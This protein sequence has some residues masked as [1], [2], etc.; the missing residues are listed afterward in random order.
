M[1]RRSD[2]GPGGAD[3]GRS[4]GPNAGTIAWESPPGTSAPVSGEAPSS[5]T[6]FDPLAPGYFDDPYPHYA[7]LRA[8]GP[9]HYEPQTNSYLVARYDD[10]T[11][12]LR[13]RSLMVEVSRGTPNA[14]IANELARN[15]SLEAGADKWMVFRDGDDHARL[16]RLVSQV[17]TPKAV[18]A[19]RRRTHAI[20]DHLLSQAAE[21]D[22]FDVITEF[23]RP[24][25]AQIISEMLGVP[26]P[27]IPQMLEWSHHL[28]YNVESF[29]PPEEERAIVDSTR[30]MT[31]Y[32]R[33]LL[34]RKRAH[35]DA[36]LLTALLAAGDA[37]DHLSADEIVAQ[38]VFLYFAGHETTMD[39]IGNGL[40]HLFEEPAQLRRLRDDPSIEEP[41]IEELLRFDPPLQFT[42]RFTTR[43]FEL[44]GT[45]IPAGAD[46]LL[47]LAAANR[48]PAKWG[49]DADRLDLIRPDA[50]NHLS[51][52]SGSHYCLGA[53][54]ARLEA[55]IAL[56]GLL[57]RFPDLAPVDPKPAWAHR[58][59][60]R[61]LERLPVYP[62]GS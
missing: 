30:S 28:V 2:D 54:L 14:V 47:G 26:D 22:R 58:L 9:V 13:D 55:R 60:L 10:V 52:S 62:H 11:R 53:S 17:F 29:N 31:E 24:L 36:D 41:A 57:R 19:W 61:G 1:R 8:A 35:P 59:V 15:A 18:E 7:A 34:E 33:V 20:V 50:A 32:L 16:R 27:D 42:R 51:F 38:V 56:P 12:L 3:A 6:R 49:A 45:E 5:V 37:S 40:T 4:L 39:L 21:R 25:P 23:A 43:A 44:G 48:D 46:V